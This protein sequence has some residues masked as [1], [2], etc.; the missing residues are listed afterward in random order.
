MEGKPAQVLKFPTTGHWRLSRTS[1]QIC[2]RNWFDFKLT[3]DSSAHKLDK[4]LWTHQMQIIIRRM[5]GMKWQLPWF[6]GSNT[7]LIILF[8][9]FFSMLKIKI[10]KLFDIELFLFLTL[11]ITFKIIHDILMCEQ[12]KLYWASFPYSTT[13]FYLILLI[14]FM[15]SEFLPIWK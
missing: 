3:C 11:T 10:V 7:N 14:K 12:F 6:C 1:K 8:R 9:C 13:G 5:L 4:S 2:F 15:N